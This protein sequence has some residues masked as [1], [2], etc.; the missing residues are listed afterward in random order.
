MLLKLHFQKLLRPNLELEQ[1]ETCLVN[2]IIIKV[3]TPFIFA[4]YK[5]CFA[6]KTILVQASHRVPKALTLAKF[7]DIA[8]FD[9]TIAAFIRLFK[10]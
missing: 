4:I 10:T 5:N 9:S 1:V 6:K 2:K 7:V 3:K 8:A